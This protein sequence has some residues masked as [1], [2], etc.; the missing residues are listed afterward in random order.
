[1][2]GN[3]IPPAR[4]AKFKRQAFT[5]SKKCHDVNAHDFHRH[6]ISKISNTL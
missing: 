3:L 5:E 4:A 6:T 1:M 2:K